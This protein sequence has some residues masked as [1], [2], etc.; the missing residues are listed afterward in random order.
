M[1]ARLG[2]RHTLE[3]VVAF[4]QE[5]ERTLQDLLRDVATVAR[6]LPRASTQRD[7]LLCF[8][9]DRYSFTVA[10]LATWQAGLVAVLPPNLAVDTLSKL[11]D[12]PSRVALLHDTKVRG[13]LHVPDLL[14]AEAAAP[15]AALPH[16]QGVAA[17]VLT[18]GSTGQSQ[19]WDKTCDQL[20]SEI[21]AWM[22]RWS[23]TA[24]RVVSTAQPGHL[25]GLLF[26]VLYPL[27]AGGAFCSET[28][29]HPEA[30]G[31][32]VAA[33]QANVLVTVPVHLRSLQVLEPGQLSSVV[34]TLSSTAPLHESD[35][36]MHLERHGCPV[37]EI[38]GSTETGGIAWRQ[39]NEGAAWTPLSAVGVCV[40]P[41]ER[42]VVDSPFASDG[43][44][45]PFTT[46]D[47]V[48]FDDEGRFESLGRVDSVVKIGG[49]RV[50]L[51]EQE[52]WLLKQPEVADA[53]I[54]DVPDL[55][56]GAR[57]IA[58]IEGIDDAGPALR[59]RMAAAFEPSVI[60]KRFVF[61]HRLPRGPNGKLARKNAL[62]LVGLTPSGQVASREVVVEPRKEPREGVSTFT[63][64][65]PE[66]F[67]WFQ[68][69]FEGYPVM[70]GAVQLL[71]LIRPVLSLTHPQLGE[72]RL[73]EGLKF[74]GRICP[75]DELAVTTSLPPHGR[76][77]QSISQNQAKDREDER[78]SGSREDMRPLR[79]SEGSTGSS[80]TSPTHLSGEPERQPS[81]GPFQVSIVRE[82][83]LLTAGKLTFFPGPESARAGD[84]R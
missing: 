55:A 65:V 40:C 48:A 71:A 32:A 42:L 15:L 4:G 14:S 19:A 51:L 27:S 17:R 75:G 6:A 62:A 64:R 67:L 2:S 12:S 26:S 78:S 25:Y 8:R 76:A 82:G 9:T 50:H 20:L 31:A 73:A 39:R 23:D 24:P 84:G 77:R 21:G 79:A 10:L 44:E 59:A 49:K 45:R 34:R 37:T 1:M 58:L 61:L 22:E 53:S 43:L 41:D 36:Q 72:L 81:L 56:R 70:A 60:P 28:P 63:V 30:I 29:Q 18:S 80:P 16:P 66:D 35:A 11:I 83:Q 7:V 54:V 38:F 52:A 13:H 3:S 46:A 69:H 68:G 47:R 74:T 33:G 57:L 5:G